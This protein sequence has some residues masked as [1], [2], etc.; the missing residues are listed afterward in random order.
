MDGIVIPRQSVARPLAARK[1]FKGYKRETEKVSRRAD[2]KESE[3]VRQLQDAFVKTECLFPG[4]HLEVLDEPYES[5]LENLRGIS[6]SVDDVQRLT[7][8]L[9]E[10]QGEQGFSVKKAGLFLSA[11]VNNGADSEYTLLLAHLAGPLHCLAYRNTKKMFVDG[12]VGRTFGMDFQSGSAHIKGSAGM[13]AGIH[14]KGGA[15][16]IGGNADFGLGGHMRGGSITV[17]KDASHC[18]G[19][20]M[21]NGIITIKGNAGHNIGGWMEGGEIILEGEHGDLGDVIRGGRIFHKSEL[22]AGK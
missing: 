5:A 4:E 2:V 20:G 18:I 17:E 14:M 15:I 11:V 21:K 12:D 6:Y 1:R 10:L 3:A 8:A 16:T 22:I 7:I 13:H 9:A 19:N